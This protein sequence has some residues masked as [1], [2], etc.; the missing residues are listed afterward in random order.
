MRIRGHGV[1]RDRDKKD[2][3]NGIA[4]ILNL[5]SMMS[6]I[7]SPM[8]PIR[9][10][11]VSPC[12]FRIILAVDEWKKFLIKLQVALTNW[13]KA[14]LGNAS[15]NACSVSLVFWWWKKSLM[16]QVTITS[17]SQQLSNH[18]ILLVSF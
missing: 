4:V 10:W 15:T 9:M 18:F 5:M 7:N 16:L 13:P 17:Q 8:L 12:R 3:M 14:I 11:M 2:A 6:C 1:W